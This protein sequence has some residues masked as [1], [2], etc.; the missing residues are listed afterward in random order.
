MTWKTSGRTVGGRGALLRRACG[1]ALALTG[2]AAAG[3]ARAEGCKV[4]DY[5]TLPVEVQNQRATTMVKING[6]DTRFILDT[7]AFFNIMSRANAQAL[8]LTLEM[9]PPGFFISGIGGDAGI[10]VTHVRDFGILGADLHNIAFVVGG[11][12]IGMGLLGANLLLLADLDLDLSQGKVKLLRPNLACQKVS[13]A[14]WAPDGNYNVATL[15]SHDNDHDR[16]ARMTVMVNGKPVVAELDTGA[17][18]TVIT[19]RAAERVGID[20]SPGA[21]VPDGLSSGFGQKRYN[22]SVAR[23]NLY[24][25][26]TESIQNSRMRVIDGEMGVGSRDHVEMLIGLDFILSHHIFVASSQ[27]KMYFSYNGG[28]V[29]VHDKLS[30]ISKSSDVQKSTVGLDGKSEP[31]TAAA[32]GLRGQARLQEGNVAGAIDDLDKAIAMAPAD[33][34]SAPFYYARARARMT[35]PKVAEGQGGRI[36]AEQVTNAIADLDTALQLAPDKADVLMMR[37]RLLLA[38]RD[39]PRAEADIE[40]LRTLV[41]AGSSQAETLASMLIEVDKPAQ[42]IPLLDDWV[43]LH[44]EDSH[45]GDVLNTRCWARGLAGIQLE[46]AAKDCAKAIKRDGPEPTILGSQA[47]VELR[48]GHWQAALDLYTQALAKRPGMGWSRYGQALAR[49]H[50]GQA[51][52]KT[53]LAAVTASNPVIVERAKHLGLTP[54]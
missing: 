43:R 15:L 22:A 13:M 37:A 19:R 25:V 54:P 48:L 14:Y 2:L 12:D 18:S 6:K 34:A 11:S 27:R 50:L 20:L 7:G 10:N 5:G 41:P 52:G 40:R 33:P 24:Q 49:L 28:R 8:G 44:G 3:A 35:P 53:E 29:S 17:P 30:E 51:E 21:V 23:V 26:G 47:L 38:R 16:N 46:E 32:F 36:P 39:R 45:L 9:A 31:D 42:A 1:M 4:V